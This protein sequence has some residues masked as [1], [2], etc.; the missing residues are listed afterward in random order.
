ME[1]GVG[2]RWQTDRVV[3]LFTPDQRQ[4]VAWLFIDTDTQDQELRSWLTASLPH[5]AWSCHVVIAG[6]DGEGRLLEAVADYLDREPVA[7]VHLHLVTDTT[8]GSSPETD[9]LLEAAQRF[10]SEAYRERTGSRLVQ[11]SVSAT[12][13]VPR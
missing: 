6:G 7:L 10:Q 9:Q 1:C 3:T 4:P 12:I 2:R 13:S 5:C 11:K 8:G